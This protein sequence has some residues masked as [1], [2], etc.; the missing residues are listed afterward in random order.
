MTILHI[1]AIENGTDFYYLNHKPSYHG[2]S[3]IDLFF[4]KNIAC[5]P[6]VPVIIDLGIS[7][8]MTSPNGK[9]ISYYIYPRSSISNTPLIMNN[10][11]GIIDSGYRGNLKVAVTNISNNTYFIRKGDRLFQICSPD[12]SGINVRLVDTLPESDRGS[13][14]FG[15]S[16]K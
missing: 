9:Q 1:K 8:M 2:D 7:C 6:G 10:S 16:G 11:V 13:G 14:G 3:G 4:T 5:N 15:S 12:L